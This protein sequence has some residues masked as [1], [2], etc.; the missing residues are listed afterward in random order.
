MNDFFR[1]LF[2]FFASLLVVAVSF[3]PGA[4][5]NLKGAVWDI[6]TQTEAGFAEDVDP[7]YSIFQRYRYAYDTYGYL[8]L[9]SQEDGGAAVDGGAVMA[10][11]EGAKEAKEG[12]SPAEMLAASGPTGIVP[13]LSKLQDY[14]F[15]MS[16]FYSVHASTTAPRELMK[17][18]EFLGTDLSLDQNPSVPQIL[19]YHTHSQETYADYGPEHPDATVVG[20]GNHLTELLEEKGWNVFHDTS[21]YDIQGGSLDRSRAYTY[22]LDGITKILKSYPSIEVVLDVHRDG[23]GKNTRLVTELGGRQV[24]NIMFFQ[25]MCRTPE[26]TISYLPNPYL[27]GNL[28]FSFQMQYAASGWYPGY[29]RKIYMKGLRYNLHL[30]PRSALVEV[31]AQTN[32][33][34]EAMNA[35]VPLAEILDMV[36]RGGSSDT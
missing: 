23:V 27:K 13:E 7:S 21:T 19:V 29:T 33:G 4:S 9:S 12:L 11:G 5:M 22:A 28:A 32:T 35:M 10:D 31:G 20:V 14:D 34:E 8:F 24:A 25:G 30:R 26:G 18:E 36:L 16:R 17:A 2:C 6:L 3:L 15:L 1:E